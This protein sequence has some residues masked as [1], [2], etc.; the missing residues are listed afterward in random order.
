MSSLKVARFLKAS[1]MSVTAQN[2][3]V[4]DVPVVRGGI[5]F[6]GEPK[7]HSVLKVGV[8]ERFVDQESRPIVRP[9][10]VLFRCKGLVNFSLIEF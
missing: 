2:I 3:P 1:D 9:V 10:R 8:G 7:I 4:A 5:R 6:V